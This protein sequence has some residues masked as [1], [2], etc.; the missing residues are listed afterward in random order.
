MKYYASTK[1][2]KIISLKVKTQNLINKIA[3]SELISSH[4][5]DE[6]W[7]SPLLHLETLFCAADSEVSVDLTVQAANLLSEKFSS[8][9]KKLINL[10]KNTVQSALEIQ[11]RIVMPSSE[12]SECF[13]LRLFHSIFVWNIFWSTYHSELEWRFWFGLC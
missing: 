10:S 13:F 11:Q 5:A 8:Q 4:F 3:P 9:A 2:W 6:G 12:N 7:Q 1:K